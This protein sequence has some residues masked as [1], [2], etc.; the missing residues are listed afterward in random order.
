MTEAEAAAT[1]LLDG[2]YRCPC[3][4]D[5]FRVA[6]QMVSD[7]GLVCLACRARHSCGLYY[8]RGHHWL[9]RDGVYRMRRVGWVR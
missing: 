3:G 5:E 4:G 6:G 8:W 2:W 7:G 1:T 9:V